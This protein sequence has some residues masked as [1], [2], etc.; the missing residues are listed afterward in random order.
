MKK[1][2]VK[3]YFLPQLQYKKSPSH[4]WKWSKQTNEH[5]A[6]WLMAVPL[7]TSL[8]DSFTIYTSTK[9]WVQ[10][11]FNSMHNIKTWYTRTHLLSQQRP[12]IAC[13]FSRKM[14]L[15]NACM[16]FEIQDLTRI[17]FS[18]NFKHKYRF[19]NRTAQGCRSNP[20]VLICSKI[21]NLSFL[22]GYTK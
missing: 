4:T 9:I 15:S 22:L 3:L 21:L 11:G 12:R 14:L 1:L 10:K 13:I 16:N 19:T 2:L 6:F 5:V 20:D 18:K 7:L 17:I 8:D